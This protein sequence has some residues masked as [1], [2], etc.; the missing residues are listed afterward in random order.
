LIVRLG[1]AGWPVAHSRSPAMHNAALAELGLHDWRYQKLPI[2]PERFAETV[3]AL[4]SR[5]FRGINV[6]IPHKEAALA[7]ADTATE[8]ARAVGAANTLTFADGRIEADN[9]DVG[10]LIDALGDAHHPRGRRALVLGAGGAGRAAVHALVGAG[11][12]DVQVWNRSP[13]RAIQVAGELGARA[14]TEPEAADLIV[15]TTSVGLKEP[16]E[17]FKQLPLEADTFQAGIC[18]VDLVYRADDTTFLAAARSRGADVIDGLEVLVGQG[19]IALERWT[20]RPAPRN[21][22]RRGATDE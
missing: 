17:P 4:Q 10:G 16:Q 15:Q 13:E 12:A 11:A 1:V 22:M 19:A 21:T 7:V 9:T 3:R 20:G 5:G 18:V 6:T 8:V 2:R 14:V